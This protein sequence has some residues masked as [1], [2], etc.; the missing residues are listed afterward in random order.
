MTV[1]GLGFKVQGIG[2][3]FMIYGIGLKVQ[4]IGFTVGG[5]RFSV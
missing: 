4:D 1:Y 3:G 2:V 5:L